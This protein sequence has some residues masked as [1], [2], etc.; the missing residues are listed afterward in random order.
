MVEQRPRNPSENEN[1]RMPLA[2]LGA[3]AQA[4]INSFTDVLKETPDVSRV[5][6]ASFWELPRPFLIGQEGAGDSSTGEKKIGFNRGDSFYAISLDLEEKSSVSVDRYTIKEGRVDMA[7]R[8]RL[9]ALVLRE[10]DGKVY[11]AQIYYINE[12]D[13]LDDR[14]YG[15]NKNAVSGGKKLLDKLREGR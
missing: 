2:E 13:P 5:I 3:E 12:G 11:S 7:T 10:D 14:A 8:E 6:L 9:R 1:Q 15:D 4:I